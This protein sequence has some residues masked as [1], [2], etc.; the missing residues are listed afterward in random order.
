MSPITESTPA[1]VDDLVAAYLEGATESDLT[2]DPRVDPVAALAFANCMAWPELS[3]DL[4]VTDPI[5]ITALVNSDA[6][7]FGAMLRTLQGLGWELVK[8]E[9]PA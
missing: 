2:T 8:V 4:V 5:N 3:P 1:S 9:V 7:W 6:E